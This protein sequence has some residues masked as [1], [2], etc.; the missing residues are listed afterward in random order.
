MLS[1]SGRRQRGFTLVELMVGVVVGLVVLAGMSAVYLNAARGSRTSTTANQLNQDLRAV[2]DIMV[3]DIR[4]AGYWSGATNGAN[5]FTTAATDL[6]ISNAGTCILYS[7]DATYSGGTGG[8][9]DAGTD[10]LGFRL[11]AGGVIQTLDP[12]VGLATT[13]TAT[14]C[15]TDADWQNLTDPLTMSVTALTI[16]TVGSKCISFPP[17]TYDAMDATTY[18]SWTTTGGTGPACSATNANGGPSTAPPATNASVETRQINITLTASSLIDPTMSRTLTE[19][20]L[21]R[22]NRLVNP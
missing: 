4:R 12:L 11:S 1:R 9:L 17:A 15:A 21:V 18:T 16:N 22:N 13:T 10:V 6:Q 7:Y 20:V 5:P 14:P 19:S 3:N 2:M 8:V